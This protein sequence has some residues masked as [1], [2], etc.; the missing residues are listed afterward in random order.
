MFSTPGGKPA[1]MQTCA[2]KAAVKGVISEGL[3]T[4]VLPVASAGAIFQVNRYSGRFHGE[5][6]ATTPSGWRKV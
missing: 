3:A 5:M 2:N 1:S 6:Q 4:T